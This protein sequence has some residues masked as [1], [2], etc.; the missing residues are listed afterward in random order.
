[1]LTTLKQRRRA[2]NRASQRA[3]RERKEKHVQQLEHQLEE[4]ETKHRELSQS[5]SNLDNNHQEL[6]RESDKLRQELDAA[7]NGG[8]S[9]SVSRSNSLKPGT[10]HDEWTATGGAAGQSV[11]QETESD[12]FFD[13]FCGSNG[14]VTAVEH[15]GDGIEFFHDGGGQGSGNWPY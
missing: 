4:L 11:K 15:S 12:A 8:R 14:G 3:F 2:Q 13:P 7:R 6:K 5:Y 1:M 9:P 10:A